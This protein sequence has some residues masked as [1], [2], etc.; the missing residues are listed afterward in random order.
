MRGKKKM[1]R[2]DRK[3][4]RS[5]DEFETTVPARSGAALTVT[6]AHDDVVCVQTI[7]CHPPASTVISRHHL[8]SS[9]IVS[10]TL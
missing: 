8:S 2:G 10:G 9:G 3:V 6:L 1:F 4:A 7:I 5:I